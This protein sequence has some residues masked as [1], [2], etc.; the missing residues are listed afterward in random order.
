MSDAEQEV[1]RWCRGKPRGQGSPVMRVMTERAQRY[2]GY[3]APLVVVDVASTEPIP[4]SKIGER[5]SRLVAA[6]ETWEAVLAA[7]PQL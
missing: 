2:T 7:L 5:R 1:L 4:G 6:G 3:P